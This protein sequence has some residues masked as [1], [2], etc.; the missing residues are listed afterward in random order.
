MAVNS[1]FKKAVFGKYDIRGIYPTEVDEELV[2]AVAEGLADKV[3]ISGKVIVAHDA[4]N[5]SPA[6][7]EAVLAALRGRGALEVVEVGLI[8]TPMLYF[9]VISEGAKGGIMVTASHNAKEQNGLK[10]VGEGAVMLSGED[11]YKLLNVPGKGDK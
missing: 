1:V 3:F 10:V 9:L 8:T 7:Y 11:I 6:L 5:S 4:R 2:G